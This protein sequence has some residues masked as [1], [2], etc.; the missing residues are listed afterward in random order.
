MADKPSLDI[1]KVIDQGA[2]HATLN[3]LKNRGV[4]NVKVGD[5][6]STLP[7]FSR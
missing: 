5:R 7:A 3:D 4:T 2:Q 1:K 6:V